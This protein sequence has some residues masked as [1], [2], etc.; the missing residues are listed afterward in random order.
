MTI[1]SRN[2]AE[3]ARSRPELNVRR[4]L[5]AAGLRYRVDVAPLPTDRRRRADVVFTRRKIAAP[6][7]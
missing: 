5:H 4:L 1:R 7:S 3:V 2:P 6:C